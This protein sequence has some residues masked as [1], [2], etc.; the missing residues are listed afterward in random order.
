MGQLTITL[1]DTLESE[2]RGA[3]SKG[4]YGSVSDFIRDAIRLELSQKPRYWERVG[5]V[6]SLENNL[7]LKELVDESKLEKNELL[8]ALRKGYS[9]DYYDVEYIAQRGELSSEGSQ[10]VVDVL[11]MYSALQYAADVHNMSDDVKKEVVFRGFDGN[12]GDGYLGYTNFLVDNG[13]FAN[14]KPLD[15]VPHLNSHSMVNEIYERMLSAFKPIFKS[16][17]HGP[18]RDLVLTPGEVQRVIDEQ[19]HPENRK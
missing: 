15:K 5:I 9:S 8:S 7:M 4:D 10:F 17:I 12:A 3:V 16:K 2:V 6:L 1:P 14:V 11:N 18:S 13:S 19:I